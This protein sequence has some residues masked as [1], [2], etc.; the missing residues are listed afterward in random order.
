VTEAPVFTPAPGAYAAAQLV[1]LSS[2]TIGAKVNYTTDGSDPSPTAGTPFTGPIPVSSSTTLKAIA[3]SSIL[4]DSPVVAGSYTIING[5]ITVSS[6]QGLYAIALPEMQPGLFV[7]QLEVAPSASESIIGFALGQPSSAAGLAVAVRFSATGFVQAINGANYA[8]ASSIPYTAGRS[9]RLRFVINVP[10]RTYSAYVMPVGS[11]ERAIGLNYA[12]QSS[13]SGVGALDTVGIFASDGS[14]FAGPVSISLRPTAAP[15]ASPA[16][17][18]YTTVQTVAL[19]SRSPG[20]Y[21][22]YTLDGS[23]PTAVH[24]TLYSGPITIATNTTL[25][26]VAYAAGSS[27]SSVTTAN[28]TLIL[29][30]SAPV[31]SPAGGSYFSAQNVTLSSSTPGASFRYTTDGSTPT[32]ANGAVYTGPIPVAGNLTL[33]AIALAPGFSASPVATAD[34][35]ISSLSQDFVNVP[36]SA[37]QSDVFALE[38]DVTPTGTQT[39]LGLSSGSQTSVDGMAAAAMFGT[40]GLIEA[41]DGA[42]FTSASPVPYVLGTQYRLRFVV[43]VTTRTYSLYATPEGGSRQLI[44][45]NVRFGP[46]QTSV[47]SLDTFNVS[48]VGSPADI[49]PFA[50][51]ATQAPAVW[52][53]AG[54]EVFTGTNSVEGPITAGSGPALTVSFFATPAQLAS[55]GPIDKLPLTGTNGWSLKLRNNGQLWFRIGS[56]ATGSRTDVVAA[57]VYTAGNRVHIACTFAAGTAV[58]YVNGT[59][60]QTRTGIV[61]GVANT[62]TKLRLGIPSVAATSNVYVGTLERVKIYDS[63][64]TEQQIALLAD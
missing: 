61:Q 38:F 21:I 7:A 20:A 2:P 13:Q 29:P 52:T 64:L 53:Y 5:G 6:E 48:T 14:V 16:G 26:A 62:L 18:V 35:V 25:K 58:I 63:A 39:I 36:L 44:G 23:T 12:F 28:Y 46:A 19:S 22:R 11:T 50:L 60:V 8:A 49:G 34:Y 24:G 56:E 33:K 30:A 45:K 51:T 40:T 47:V 10:A 17:G 4:P 54:P 37:A 59:A 57:N 43:D 31:F 32:L 55:M 3:Y 1:T 27:P 15:S 9:Y 41:R 42:S